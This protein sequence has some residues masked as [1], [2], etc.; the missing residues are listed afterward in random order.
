MPWGNSTLT[1]IWNEHICNTYAWESREDFLWECCMHK[2]KYVLYFEAFEWCHTLRLHRQTN[3]GEICNHILI[4]TSV[5]CC[6]CW[7][8]VTI[9]FDLL[10]SAEITSYLI[11]CSFTGILG[12]TVCRAAVSCWTNVHRR[13]SLLRLRRLWL[14]T[15]STHRLPA[16]TWVARTEHLT[17]HVIDACVYKCLFMFQLENKRD[18]FFPP[19]HQFC[20]NPSNPVTVIRGLAG[21]LKLGQSSTL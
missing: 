4:L 9:N 19:L 2:Q 1:V 12:R 5:S 20:T 17:L 11:P 18:A 3:A 16:S 15:N 7:E 8:F 13:D 10:Y 21:A 6:G 14:K